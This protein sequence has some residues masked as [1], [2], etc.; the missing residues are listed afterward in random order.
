MSTRDR[1]RRRSNTKGRAFFWVG[2][3][4]ILVVV[5]ISLF[6]IIIKPDRVE[7]DPITLCP[8]E[9]GPSAY[10]AIVIDRTD[11]FGAISKADIEVQI[12]DLLNSVAK[13][14]QVSLFVVE[15]VE[16]APL[17]SV[18]SV[19]NP[20]DP[21]KADPLTQNPELI[22]RNWRSKFQE[23]LDALLNNL[24]IEKEASLSPIMESI[25]SV[26]ITALSGKEKSSRPRRII[27]ISDLLQ[28]SKSWSLYTQKPDFNSFSKDAS[29]RGLNP[30]LSGV[31]FQVLYLQRETKNQIKDKE[32]HRFWV[33]WIEAFGGKVTR[34]LKVSGI[35]R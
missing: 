7:K 12:K 19:C 15:P 26:S 24:L 34:F 27:L 30:V 17:R 20:G 9:G 25:Q 33:S 8:I 11:S 14:E 21:S 6:L 28:N 5:G 22:A 4:L 16:K 35:N 23:P 32:L 10:T 1:S 31:T 18:I 3:M 29:T 13:N 2:I